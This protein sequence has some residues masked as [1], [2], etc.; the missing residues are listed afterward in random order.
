MPKQP[1]RTDAED[2]LVISEVG[3]WAEEKHARLRSYIELA[4][5][6]RKGYLPPPPDWRAGPPML[7]FSPVLGGP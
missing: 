2:G 6:V 3:E 4:G 1:D 5:V 7:S